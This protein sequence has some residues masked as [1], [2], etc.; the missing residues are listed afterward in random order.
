MVDARNSEVLLTLT[1]MANALTTLTNSNHRKHSNQIFELS[2]ITYI[3]T[4]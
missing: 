1:P 2:E 4:F 3:I